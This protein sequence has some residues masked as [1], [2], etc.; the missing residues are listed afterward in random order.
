MSIP[1]S[2]IQYEN[3]LHKNSLKN[4]KGAEK[5]AFERLPQSSYG[6]AWSSEPRELI[7]R[8]TDINYNYIE[9]LSESSATGSV[10]TDR[11]QWDR[12]DR[13]ASKQASKQTSAIVRSNGFFLPS[14]RNNRNFVTFRD[15]N[16]S[17][18]L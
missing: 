7:A 16:D 4:T 13:E 6:A 1:D 11:V 17:T 15:T 14:C 8:T 12:A 10:R 3:F 9:K 18:L 2:N 5:F